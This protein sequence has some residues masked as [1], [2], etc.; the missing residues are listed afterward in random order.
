MKHALAK[1]IVPV[2]LLLTAAPCF[3]WGR[4]GHK[5]VSEIATNRLTPEARADVR[6]LLGD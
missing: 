2:L 5:I 6:A 4:D 1:R 3:G